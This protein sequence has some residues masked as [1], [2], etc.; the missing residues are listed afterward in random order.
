[1][2]RIL[3]NLLIMK[4]KSALRD[5]EVQTWIFTKLVERGRMFSINNENVERIVGFLFRGRREIGN[6]INLTTVSCI[7]SVRFMF[8]FFTIFFVYSC[9]EEPSP[10]LIQFKLNTLKSQLIFYLTEPEIFITMFCLA[11]IIIYSI[12][13]VRH[14][15]KAETHKNFAFM[16]F[17]FDVDIRSIPEVAKI[18]NGLRP[19]RNNMEQPNAH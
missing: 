2:R 14:A 11:L 16:W 17:L 6:F 13:A 18:Y 8:T 15:L 5:I 10:D 1:M 12:D 19:T 7:L 4:M 9:I 3:I